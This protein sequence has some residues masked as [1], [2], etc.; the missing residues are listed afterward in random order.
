MIDL[1]DGYTVLTKQN[2]KWCEKIKKLLPD[3]CYILCEVPPAPSQERDAFFKEVDA[4]SRT[5]PRTFP[6]VFYNKVYIG[7]YAA[8]KN[9]LEF[10]LMLDSAYF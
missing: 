1:R 7:G 4:L 6:M 8:T 10:D 5:K 3:A 9:K 2:C